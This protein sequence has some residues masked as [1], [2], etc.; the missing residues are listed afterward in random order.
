MP[1]R[2]SLVTEQLLDAIAQTESGNNP[3]A[4][5]DQHLS[6]QAYGAFQ[7]RLPAYQDVQRLYPSEFGAIPFANIQQDAALQRKAAR[8]YL[9]GLEAHYGITDLDRLIAGYNA[10][11][12]VRQGTIPNPDYVIKVKRRLPPTSE[13][14]MDRTMQQLLA[15]N[16]HLQILQEFGVAPLSVDDIEQIL[17][18]QAQPAMPAGGSAMSATQQQPLGIG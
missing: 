6:N 16:K 7:M 10:G 17:A 3:A 1:R 12:R 18:Q 14:P 8:R 2:S 9:E 13:A 11:P 4:R 15:I 5:G